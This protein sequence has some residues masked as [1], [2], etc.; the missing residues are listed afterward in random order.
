MSKTFKYDVII[1]EEDLCD[2]E[3]EKK[4]LLSLMKR[5]GR[6]VIYSLRRM[7]KTSLVHVCGKKYKETEPNTFRFYIDL[8][9]LS[10]LA[11]VAE[12]FRSHYELALNEHFPIQV[13][14]SFMS[15][16]LSKVKISLP[17]DVEL[18][19]TKYEIA[20][21]EKYLLSLFQELKK[22]SEKHKLIIIID[23]FQGIAELK[24]AQAI[25]RRE[26]KKL[27]K[28][29]VVLMGS[30]QRLLYKM[31]NDKHLPF[32]GFGE[33]MELK[34]I[35]VDHYHP[36]MNERFA[37][38]NLSIPKNV[39]EYFVEVMNNIPN[40][41][42]ELGAWIVDTMKDLNLT[43][44]HIDEALEAAAKS[45][46][47]RY[48]S[49]LYGY[50]SNQKKFVKAVARLGRVKSHTGKEM[51]EQTGLSATE[52]SRVKESLEDAPILSLDTNNQFFIIDPFFR[53]FLEVM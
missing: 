14:K 7:G 52:L 6:I 43:K 20:Q 13:A 51:I 1:D 3:E 12:R 53:R 33:D 2:R 39:A 10:S 22:I 41:I 15:D 36:Y 24:D 29:A 44:G 37:E 45:K 25:L 34:P 38:S 27:T 21:P 30:N 32:F 11:E 28:S 9:E 48:E 46:R 17:G 23:E 26:L 18:S 35:S 42:N 47:G 4:R 40:Y 5:N 16:L 49:A 31:F 50:T 8:N 19:V